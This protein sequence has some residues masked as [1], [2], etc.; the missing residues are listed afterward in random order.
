MA[1]VPSRARWQR[2]ARCG[3]RAA[4]GRG[5]ERGDPSLSRRENNCMIMTKPKKKFGH[6]G[7]SKLQGVMGKQDPAG[8]TPEQPLPCA[9][10]RR[11]GARAAHLY[12]AR[13]ERV[14][15]IQARVGAAPAPQRRVRCWTRRV[16]LVRGEGR[17]VS[18]S[19][20]MRGR[21]MPAGARCGGPPH[22]AGA[23]ERA[24]DLVHARGA[25]R[26]DGVRLGDAGEGWGERAL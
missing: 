22:V 4:A 13:R 8:I 5:P 9:A 10:P 3:G 1:R 21:A 14:F 20:G 12:T 6:H 25:L 7:G 2:G 11:A 19:T 26:G 23:A 17:D 24:D 16:R 18:V 15:G